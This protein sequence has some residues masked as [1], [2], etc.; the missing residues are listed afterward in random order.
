LSLNH[1]NVKG[2][3]KGGIAPALLNLDTDGSGEIHVPSRL[4]PGNGVG[5]TWNRRSTADLEIFTESTSLHQV[6]LNFQSL[7]ITSYN[8]GFKI[9]KFCVLPT[10]HLYVLCGS[11]NKLRLFLYT[12]LTYG[13]L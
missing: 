9:Q 3:R 7:S 13:F 4:T 6:S 1:K 2:Q 11:E 10:V 8:T 5:Y 12:A